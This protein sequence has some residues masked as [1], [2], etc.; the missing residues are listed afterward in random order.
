MPGVSARDAPR[1][2]AGRYELEELLGQGG[3]GEVWRAKHLALK[4]HVAL[5]L[6][7]GAV[8]SDPTTRERFLTEAQIT[9]S[10][11]TRHAV[12]VFDFGVTEEGQPYLV[13]ELVEGEPLD[14]RLSRE[15]RLPRAET[16]KLLGRAAR[17][18]DRAHA[19]GI[20]HRDFKPENIMIFS[21]EDGAD[22]V[23]VVDFGVAKILGELGAENDFTGASNPLTSKSRTQNLVGT[24]YYM[25][26]EQINDPS[27]V[28]PPADIWAFGVVAYECLTGARPFEDD[29]VPGLLRRILRGEPV[30]LGSELAHLPKEFDAWFT[31]ACQPD[32]S[33]R[34]PDAQ[35]AL[36]ALAVVLDVPAPAP[37]RRAG[38]GGA[39]RSIPDVGTVTPSVR[40]ASFS[41]TVDARAASGVQR[42]VPPER[43]SLAAA[44]SASGAPIPVV[45]ATP[46][47]GWKVAVAAVAI[48]LVGAALFAIQSS[49][50]GRA[51][52]AP[53][54]SGAALDAPSS[55]VKSTA[56]R[57][58]DRAG[59]AATANPIASSADRAATPTAPS[60]V[61]GRGLAARD[62]AQGRA[63][64]KASAS[65]S[66]QPAPT[67]PPAAPPPAPASSS[68][69][70]LPPL[71]L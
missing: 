65:A 13:M 43:S 58:D 61:A 69:F 24:P 25:S 2:I 36:T 10:L 45:Q 47:R 17:A 5:K 53:S 39:R 34:F 60:G 9:A 14:R 21:D 63:A 66:A 70:Q 54:V 40:T 42:S 68:P 19:L 16:V 20:V 57:D 28:G 33:L 7:H 59:G 49:D 3:M 71:G 11:K 46:K 22:D 37:A 48:A 56:A 1:T 8:A 51:T 52:S 62:R 32:P 6:L 35:T 50:A 55:V 30:A 26:P 18:L 12:Q 31:A 29:T 23:K 38:G 44:M 64:A 41:D 67:P 27:R 4:S 15:L